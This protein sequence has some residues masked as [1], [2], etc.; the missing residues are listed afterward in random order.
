[1]FPMKRLCAGAALA[2]LATIAS[3]ATEHKTLSIGAEAPDF[4][5][6]A[7]D[8]KTYRLADFNSAKVLAI[9][10]TCNHCATAQAYE[11]R[12]M[13]LANDYKDKGV[14]LVAD[15]L[16]RPAGPPPR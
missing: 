2:C 5:L 10:F 16:K 6:P 9:V 13:Q 4:S 14:T 7:V 11:D 12:L 3:A 1:M 15:L 8:G